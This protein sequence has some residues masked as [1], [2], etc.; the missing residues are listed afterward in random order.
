MNCSRSRIL[1][2]FSKSVAMSRITHLLYVTTFDSHLLISIILRCDSTIAYT[3]NGYYTSTC[4]FVDSCT[5]ASKWRSPPLCPSM[6]FVLPQSVVPQLCLPP[7]LQW[8]KVT[9]GPIYFLACQRLLLLHKNSTYICSSQ[10][11]I[12]NYH[13]HKLYLLIIC[14]PLCAFQRWWWMWWQPYS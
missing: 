6:L 13:L 3:S 4:T 7:I 5:S 11:Y 2:P 12:M 9:I 14:L 10:I 1:I 8:I